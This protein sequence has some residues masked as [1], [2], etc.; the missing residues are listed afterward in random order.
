MV[1]R[2]GMSKRIDLVAVGDAD[3]QVTGRMFPSF[4]SGQCSDSTAQ[5][6]DEEVRRLLAE[7]NDR[8]TQTLDERRALLERIAQRAGAARGA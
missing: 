5:L 3:G 6:I 7:A 8:V 1:A 2:Y 4:N